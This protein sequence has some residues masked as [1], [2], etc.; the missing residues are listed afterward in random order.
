M[1]PLAASKILESLAHGSCPITGEAL[2]DS[3]P[4][5]EPQVIRALFVA[6]ESLRRIQSEGN[7]A[8]YAPWSAEDDARL[9]ASYL[10]D[11]TVD[12]LCVQSNRSPEEVKAR[13]IELGCIKPG[14]RYDYYN[15]DPPSSN[16]DFI[17]EGV[18]GNCSEHGEKK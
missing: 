16:E 7:V 3:N 17:L 5:N 9:A 10:E 11:A 13:L 15:P 2:A 8:E 4:L 1:T 12:Q 18:C 14:V 6:I